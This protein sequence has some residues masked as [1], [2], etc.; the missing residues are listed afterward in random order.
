MDAAATAVV[1]I[2]VADAAFVRLVYNLFYVTMNYLCK[3]IESNTNIH[4]RLD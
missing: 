2:V 1:V 4:N 3:L